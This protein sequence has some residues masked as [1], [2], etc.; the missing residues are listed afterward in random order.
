MSRVIRYLP[1]LEGNEQVEVASLMR[2]M[3]DE[4]VEQFAHVY[5]SRR[6]DPQ[7]VLLLTLLGL[8]VVAGVQRFYVGQIGMGV[9]YLLTGGLCFVGTIVDIVKHKE[10]A[11]EHNVKQAREAAALIG[12]SFR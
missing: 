4:Q 10:I 7:T 6:K 12:G 1:E 2:G 8:F 11:A 5:R 9:L 3:S